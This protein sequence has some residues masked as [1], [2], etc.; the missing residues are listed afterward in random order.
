M[1]EKYLQFS[2]IIS[3]TDNNHQKSTLKKTYKSKYLLTMM[4]QLKYLLQFSV[5]S[6]FLSIMLLNGL[7]LGALPDLCTSNVQPS[8]SDICLLTQRTYCTEQS[9]FET[10]IKQ[11]VSSLTK[12]YLAYFTINFW[13]IAEAHTVLGNKTKFVHVVPW[14]MLLKYM[15]N[16]QRD[17]DTHEQAQRTDGNKK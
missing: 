16:Q 10:C 13:F 17:A 9:S 1:S 6:C 5:Q 4:K 7:K 11:H 12:T 14:D 3:K 2:N 15:I 8:S